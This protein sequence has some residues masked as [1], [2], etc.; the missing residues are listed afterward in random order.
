M[1]HFFPA[2]LWL[3]AIVSLFWAFFCLVIAIPPLRRST[4][5]DLPATYTDEYLAGFMAG[6]AAFSGRIEF[7]N[8]IMLALFVGTVLTLFVPKRKPKTEPTNLKHEK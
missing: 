7:F 6:K 5:D 3:G 8:I 2:G 4:V 1:K